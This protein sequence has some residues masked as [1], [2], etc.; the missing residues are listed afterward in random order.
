MLPT[1]K[2][3]RRPP[4]GE[5]NY[6][7]Q[8]YKQGKDSSVC[9]VSVVRIS[10]DCFRTGSGQR[11]PETDAVVIDSGEVSS[12]PIGPNCHVIDCTSSDLHTKSRDGIGGLYDKN[13]S[14]TRLA[15][16]LTTRNTGTYLT[17]S[18]GET[19]GTP[20]MMSHY[21]R[22]T[23]D[24]NLAGEILAALANLFLTALRGAA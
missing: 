22:P 8:Y 1:F 16:S 4:T 6:R 9:T 11:P 15:G 21:A 5:N 14:L 19:K 20:T 18:K 13:T 24:I 12:T 23:S 2:G 3:K 17:I 7:L 10:N